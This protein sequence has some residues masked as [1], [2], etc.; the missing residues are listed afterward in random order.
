MTR[1]TRLTRTIRRIDAYT[2]W[3]FNAE[4]ALSRRPQR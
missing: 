2:L 1:L 3:A 4:S